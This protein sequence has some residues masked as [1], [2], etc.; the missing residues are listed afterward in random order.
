MQW[1]E[2]QVKGD[3]DE[4]RVRYRRIETLASAFDLPLVAGNLGWKMYLYLYLYPDL[5]EVARIVMLSRILGSP[6]TRFLDLHSFVRN[7]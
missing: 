1:S 6:S 2:K 7:R 4:R 5:A 3:Q